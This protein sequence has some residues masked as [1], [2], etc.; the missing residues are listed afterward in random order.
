MA[1]QDSGH[2]RQSFFLKAKLSEGSKGHGGGPRA[3]GSRSI[4]ATPRDP[5]MNA[6]VNNA[7]SSANGWVLLR[8]TQ[9]GKRPVGLPESATEF[10][11]FDPHGKCARRKALAVIP[12]FTQSTAAPRPQTVEKKSSLL[13]GGLLDELKKRTAYRSS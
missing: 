12:S 2:S 6:K 13:T 5:E 10:D 1:I 4:L 7:V 9:E 11:V 3:L 8:H